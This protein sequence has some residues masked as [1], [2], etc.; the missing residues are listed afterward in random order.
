MQTGLVH[1]Y[2]GDG[3]GKT[4]AALGLALRACGRGKKVL[5]VRFL[6]N[7]DSGEV[8]VLRTLPGVLVLP[9]M[10]EIKFFS[11][12]SQSE[13]G[14]TAAFCQES[15]NTA[16][17][18]A[19][20]ENYDMLVLDEAIGAVNYGFLELQQLVALVETRPE[21]LEIVLTGRRPPQELLRLADYISEVH[22]VRHPFD[23]GI[24]ARLGIER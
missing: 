22:K 16:G 9:A 18:I 1:I 13:R 8:A 3:K 17:T 15:L 12:M 24:G 23:R 5:I 4:S 11:Q 20:Q 10:P 7:E 21:A 2:C 6:K 14:H 19:F